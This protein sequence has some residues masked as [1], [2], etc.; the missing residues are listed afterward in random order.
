MAGSGCGRVRAKTAFLTLAHHIIN[1]QLPGDRV[2]VAAG[3]RLST[4]MV[5]KVDTWKWILTGIV[6]PDDDFDSSKRF[7]RPRATGICIFYIFSYIFR[8]FAMFFNVFCWF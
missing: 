7:V 6:N 1:W 5:Q 4:W 2:A 3:I 8:G